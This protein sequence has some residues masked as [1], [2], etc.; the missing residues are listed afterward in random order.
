[1]GEQ[2]GVIG[3]GI[4]GLLRLVVPFLARRANRGESSRLFMVAGV[5]VL[6]YFVAFTVDGYLAAGVQLKG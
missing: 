5:L 6:V 1:M 2:L 3:F 4:A